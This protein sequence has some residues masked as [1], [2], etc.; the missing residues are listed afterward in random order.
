MAQGI[1][2]RW[3]Q[4]K[5]HAGI[6]A[7]HDLLYA[8]PNTAA[9][10]IWRSEGHFGL[11][12]FAKLPEPTL[13]IA[14][15]DGQII[16]ACSYY[17]RMATVQGRQVRAAEVNSV[18]V[19]PDWRGRRLF[20]QMEAFAV[21]ALTQSGIELIDGLPTGKLPAIM[22]AGAYS[23]LGRLVLFERQ[24]RPLGQGVEV[25]PTTLEGKRLEL[26]HDRSPEARLRKYQTRQG[27]RYRLVR[28]ADGDAMCKW[29]GRFGRAVTLC[30]LSPA[31]PVDRRPALLGQVTRKLGRMPGRRIRCWAVEGSVLAGT[32]V[33]LG[34]VQHQKAALEILARPT[35]NWSGGDVGVLQPDVML[36]DFDVG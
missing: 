31:T 17:P 5:D 34:F 30:D 11:S 15:A 19:H 10:L 21:D 16:A 26:R 35:A 20:L 25:T 14:E 28:G 6:L 33:G 3:C 36:G 4:R 18:M 29:H 13:C 8:R 22:L 7:L 32:L 9:D 2:I 1:T 24:G 12:A 27:E 23:F